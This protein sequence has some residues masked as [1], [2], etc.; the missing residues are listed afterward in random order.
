[1]MNNRYLLDTHALLWSAD[2]LTRFSPSALNLISDSANQFFFSQI[3]LFEI[4]I[5]LKIGK[6]PGATGSVK[7]L[8]DLAIQNDFTLLNLENKHIQ[9]YDQVPLFQEHRDPFDR[10]LI[11]QAISEGLPIITIDEKF[12]LYSDQVRIVW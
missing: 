10:I 12:N 8:F 4:A 6:M 11:A 1:M 3:S 5:K 2:D 7:E 9:A